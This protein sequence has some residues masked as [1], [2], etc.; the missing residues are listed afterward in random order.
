M[1]AGLKLNQTLLGRSHEFFT[2]ISP[3]ICIVVSEFVAGLI[4]RIPFK[5]S[6][7]YLPTPKKLEHSV[8]GSIFSQLK[9]YGDIGYWSGLYLKNDSQ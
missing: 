2:I 9:L 5:K 8:E 4:S 7:E 1:D 6:A 3:A